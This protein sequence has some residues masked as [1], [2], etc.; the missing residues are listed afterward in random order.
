MD[1]VDPAKSASLHSI[2]ERLRARPVLKTLGLT[3]GMTAFFAVYF[4]VLNNP[5]GPVTVIPALGLDHAIPFSPYWVFP[6][7]TLWIYVSLFPGLL[8]T[9]RE[10]LR[11]AAV[12]VGLSGTGLAI[13]YLWPTTIVQP[14]LDW[15]EYPGISFLKTI[16]AAGN[17]CPSLHVAFAVF[18]A[19][20]ID[21]LLDSLGCKAGLRWGN[22]L[23]ALAI[24]YSTLATKQH[25]VIDVLAGLVLGS[26][27]AIL[28]VSLPGSR[29]REVRLPEN[30]HCPVKTSAR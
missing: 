19:V 28:H 12:A 27:A 1:A 9:N 24:I 29:V 18:T 21:R 17:V 10:M 20:G 3:L 25:V 30:R 13:F 6:Y 8:M 4:A 16:D 7:I 2:R 5:R 15:S 26:L 11:Y 14:D 22:S 23:W